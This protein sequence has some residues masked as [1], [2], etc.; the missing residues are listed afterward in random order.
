ATRLSTRLAKEVVSNGLDRDGQAWLARMTDEV[1]AAL[2]EGP[3]TPAELRER[4]PPL[5]QR[6]ELSP[7]KKYGGSFPIAPRFLGTVA[8]TGRI[9]RGANAGDWRG[10]RPRG[11]LTEDVLGERPN[12]ECSPKRYLALVESW[13]RT[14]GPGTEADLVWW[15]GATKAA[16]R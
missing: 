3:A 7:G 2:A 1:L 12:P 10:P 14:F 8:A 5:A 16:V 9:L 11:I 15:F 4:I 6:L 13:L